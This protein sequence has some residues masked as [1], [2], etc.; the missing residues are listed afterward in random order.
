MFGILPINFINWAPCMRIL[1]EGDGRTSWN[2]KKVASFTE[3]NRYLQN[4][5]FTHSGGRC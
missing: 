5:W 3:E 4:T 1:S 2:T